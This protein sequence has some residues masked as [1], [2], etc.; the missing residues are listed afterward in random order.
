[1]MKI[2]VIA[3]SG[4]KERYFRD[5]ADEYIKRLRGY[6]DLKIVELEPVRLPEKPSDAEINTALDREGERILKAIPAGCTTIALCVEG[7]QLTSEE[8]ARAVKTDCDL[9]RGMVFIIGSSY[10]LSEQVKARCDKRLSFSAMTFPH[11]LFRIMLLEQLYR[12]CK[13]NAGSSYHK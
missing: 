12:A 10:G 8:F 4:L 1:M 6:C 11:R 5:C 3:V 9:G 7:K 2:T 13:I